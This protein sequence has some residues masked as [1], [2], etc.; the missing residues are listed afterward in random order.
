MFA[1]EHEIDVSA[2]ARTQLNRLNAELERRVQERTAALELEVAERR[3]G[4]EALKLSLA[5][6]ERAL[7]DLAD[8][9]FALD[10]HAVVATTDVQGTITYVNDKFCALSQYSRAELIGQNHRVVNSGYHSL[11]FFREMYRTIG[12]GKVW[13]AEICNRAKDGSLYWVDTTIVPFLDKN[14]KPRQ[15]MAIR[16][17]I[18][19]RKRAEE[20]REW[21]AAVVESSDDAIISKDLNGIITAW[22]RGAENIFG[23]SVAEAIGQPMLMLFPPDQVQEEADILARIRRGD[24]VEHLET[25]RVRKEG[26]RID[27]SVTISPIRDASGTIVG[28]STIARDI[29]ERKR[30]EESLRERD[31]VLDLAQIMVRDMQ[32]RILLW[33][34]GAE[35][36]YGYTREEA[37]GRISHELLETQFPE[38]LQQIEAKLNHAGSWEGELVHR[39]RDHASIVVSSFWVLH[40]DKAGNPTRVLEAN[41]DITG[42]KLAEE[43]LAGQAEELAL[44]AE[45]LLHSRKALEEQTQ[46]L[47]CVL[48][49]MGEGLIAADGKGKFILWNPAALTILGQGAAD[50]APDQWSEHYHVYR[51]DMKTPFPSDQLPLARA[52]RGE[53]CSAEMFVHYPELDPGVWIEASAGPLKGKDGALRGGVIAMRDITRRKSDER[54]LS[55]QAGELASSREALETQSLLLRSVLDSMSEGLVAVDEQGRFMIWNPAAERI[56]GRGAANVSPDGWSNHYGVFLADTITPFPDDQNPLTMAIRGIASSAV[57][58]IRNPELEQGVWLEVSANPLRDTNGKSCGGV[59]AFRDIT[60]RRQDE[61]KIHALNE[62]LEA[63]VVQRTAQLE[64]ANHELEAFTYSVSHDLRAPLRHIGGFSKILTEDFVAELPEEAR[65][66]LRRIEQGVHRMGLLVDELLNLARVGRHAVRLQP[67]QLNPIIEEVVCLLQPEAA[68]RAVAWKIETLAPA[69]CDPILIKQ[70]FQN[71]IAN[72]LKFSRTRERVM[73]EIAQREENGELVIMVRDNG[74]GFNM[75]YTD[76]LFGVFQR[77]HRAEDFEGTGIGLA[78]VKRIVQKHG[79]RVWAESELDKGAAFFFAL[80]AAK[81]SPEASFPMNQERPELENST[82]DKERSSGAGA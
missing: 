80:A 42:R 14:E 1:V 52:L 38:P 45:E 2:R 31:K 73:I 10:Q 29:T 56:I 12:Q 3:Q 48:D 62:E 71:L 74:V 50:V 9:K 70:V 61:E 4:A 28:A 30:V 36:L 81:S 64:A 19:E 44:Q 8:Q 72:A 82:G 37:V 79:G 41:V 18:T 75:E 13:R 60:Q 27:V 51:D 68:N 22:N 53:T 66:H 65:G 21:L 24:S 32:G 43:R 57:M 76:K 23:Y 17:D 5:T 26:G 7:R 39:K 20:A 40:R 11:E 69:L 55:R 67:T 59:A 15:Y 58:F 33:N 46:M 77:L 34:L 47:Q 63:K 49:S 54:E 6:S 78:T 16:A 25:A 35:K